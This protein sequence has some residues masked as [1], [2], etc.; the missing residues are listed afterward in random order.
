MLSVRLARD[1]RSEI[2]SHNTEH[3]QTHNTHTTTPTALQRLTAASR[4]SFGDHAARLSTG[5]RAAKEVLPDFADADQAIVQ[6]LNGALT[7]VRHLRSAVCVL[8]V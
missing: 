5:C 8:C 3:T 1:R 7:T 4:D 6:F 2:A